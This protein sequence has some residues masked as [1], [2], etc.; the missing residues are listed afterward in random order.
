MIDSINNSSSMKTVSSTIAPTAT[1]KIMPISIDQSKEHFLAIKDTLSD[2]KMWL[3]II[4]IIILKVIVI[5]LIKM[6]GKVYKIHN[7]KI[8]QRHRRI[9]PQL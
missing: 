7:E 1:A 4:A 3:I 8:I 9:S 2:I 6:C 5:K